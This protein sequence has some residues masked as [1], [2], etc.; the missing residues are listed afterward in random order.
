MIT[1]VWDG[2]A[3]SPEREAKYRELIKQLKLK[4]AEDTVDVAFSATHYGWLEYEG[5][6][7][8]LTVPPEPELIKAIKEITILMNNYLNV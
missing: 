1:R 2:A 6:H 3:K 7:K 5:I 8:S 4:Y